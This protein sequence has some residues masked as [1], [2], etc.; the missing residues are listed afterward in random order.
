MRKANRSVE[1]LKEYRKKIS[2][3]K[4]KKGSTGAKK[5]YVC[6]EC[7]I[8]YRETGDGVDCF[9]IR[10]KCERCEVNR[11]YWNR[12]L[13]MLE[14]SQ[15]SRKRLM[16]KSIDREEMIRRIYRRILEIKD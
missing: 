1:A 15:R 9:I 2:M 16:K 12:G 8:V 3:S 11:V 13:D 6:N 5:L 14:E 7:G 4:E 10:G